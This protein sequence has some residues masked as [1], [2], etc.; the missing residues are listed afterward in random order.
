MGNFLKRNWVKLSLSALS[1][2]SVAYLGYMLIESIQIF[3]RLYN[4]AAD[5]GG[6]L[7][8]DYTLM[9]IFMRLF[10]LVALIAL[11]VY[12]WR[13]PKTAE[14]MQAIADEKQL[15]AE[16]SERK[17]K[18]REDARIAALEAELA[19]LKKDKE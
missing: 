12:I 9:S 5:R 2:V 7:I 4:Q 6:I 11:T 13:K 18:E 14:E 19:E 15:R 8:H 1:A 17:R 10:C 3:F 16:E